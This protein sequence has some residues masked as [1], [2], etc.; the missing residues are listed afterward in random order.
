MRTALVRSAAD[1]L[2]DV[3]ASG[4]VDGD[5]T[6]HDPELR[7]SQVAA[8]LGVSCDHVRYLTRI[9]RLRAFVT[10][11]GHH[12]Y[13]TSDVLAFKARGQ[14]RNTSDIRVREEPGRGGERGPG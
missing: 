13:L 6:D 1:I 11:G 7:R 3:Y 9:H 14:R 5:G 4:E 8:L 2:A 10:A 12:R